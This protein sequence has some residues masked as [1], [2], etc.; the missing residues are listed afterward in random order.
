MSY[1]SRMSDE[2]LESRLDELGQEIYELE[3]KIGYLRAEEFQLE[4]ELERRNMED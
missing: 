4:S 2:E 1:L 3:A